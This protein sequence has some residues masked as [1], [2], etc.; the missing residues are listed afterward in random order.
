MKRI[1]LDKLFPYTIEEDIANS[2]SHGI[3]ALIIMVGNVYLI[4][5]ASL[6]LN[7]VNVICFAVYGYILVGMLLAS[8]LY[9]GIRHIGTRDIFK[10]LDH[11]FIFLLITG[12]YCPIVFVGLKTTQSYIVFSILCLITICGII[13]K[14]FFSDRFKILS[15]VI[16]I[17]MGWLA[18]FLIPQIISTL[19]SSFLLWIIIG[20]LSYTLGALLYAFG[21]FK[22]HHFIWHLF[23]LGGA[24]AHYIAILFY[25][26]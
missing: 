2:I 21:K 5:Q 18:V 8:C 4:Y 12:T 25:L 3:G 26:I 23:V 17:L 11:S 22:Y 20:G 14:V 13:F 6:T 24:F 1:P 10:R 16:F 7:I 19:S 15:T 9:H